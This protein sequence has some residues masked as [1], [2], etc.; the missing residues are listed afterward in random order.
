MRGRARSDAGGRSPKGSTLDG[1][2][3]FSSATAFGTSRAT[4]GGDAARGRLM[5]LISCGLA[6]EGAPMNSVIG[7]VGILRSRR[8]QRLCA[9]RASRRLEKRGADL[10][11]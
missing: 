7:V 2:A 8:D 1:G 6:V 5:A 9:A 10:L 11:G 4:G 3:G